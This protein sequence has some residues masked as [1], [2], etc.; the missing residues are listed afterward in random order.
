[1]A[2]PEITEFTQLI[3]ARPRATEIAQMR[4]D[5]DARGKAFRSA[6]GRDGAAG[7]RATV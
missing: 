5:T 7:R 6:A 1:M 2:D 4:L 3:A